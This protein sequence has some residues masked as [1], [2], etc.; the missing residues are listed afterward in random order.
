MPSVG[1]DDNDGVELNASSSGFTLSIPLL[2][3]AKVPLGSVLGKERRKV[4][5]IRFFICI[6]AFMLS[7]KFSILMTFL[8]EG[9]DLMSGNMEIAVAP[10]GE[11]KDQGTLA[12]SSEFYRFSF[13]SHP[14][15][16]PSLSLDG[17]ITRHHL[18]HPSSLFPF[19]SII[20]LGGRENNYVNVPGLPI[21]I[22][23]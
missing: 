9:L 1:A 6:D 14:P 15:S 21:P 4:Y 23:P 19:P 2:G 7:F 20:P 10:R 22:P 8:L 11:H 13:R 18:S 16:A 3:R 5:F 17:N 12:F